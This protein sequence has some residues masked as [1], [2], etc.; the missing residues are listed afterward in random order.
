MNK[1][2]EIFSSKEVVVFDIDNTLINGYTQYILLKYLFRKG[3]I[4]V[5]PYLKIIFWFFLYKIKIINNPKKIMDYA[6]G[7]LKDKTIKE[8]DDIVN[9][10]FEEELKYFVFEEGII[11]INQHISENRELLLVSSA[12]KPIVQKCA[13]YFNIKIYIST[14]LEINDGKYTGKIFGDIIYGE[15][16]A[17]SVKNFVEKNH[18]TLHCSWSYGD[19]I[20]DLHVLNITS[21]PHAVNPDKFLL[22]EAKIRNWPIL[23]FGKNIKIS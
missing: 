14:E 10:F 17:Y 9:Q 15:N 6:Y 1:N 7:F 16:K 18:L 11:L 2:R 20:T 4:K 22:Q 5:L 8:F 21:Y 13:Q 3:L 23:V 19:H 12:I